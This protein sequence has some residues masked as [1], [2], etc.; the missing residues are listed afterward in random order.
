MQRDWRAAQSREPHHGHALGKHVR[1]LFRFEFEGTAGFGCWVPK[2]SLLCF[3][4]KA[5]E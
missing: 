2:T 4:S 3:E 1:V 5:M